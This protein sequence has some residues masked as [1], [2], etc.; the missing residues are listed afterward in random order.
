MITTRLARATRWT[1]TL[2]AASLVAVSAPANA[3][4]Y[5]GSYQGG[6]YGHGH[7]GYKAYGGYKTYGHGGYYGQYNYGHYKKYNNYRYKG[8]GDNGTA[9]GIGLGVVGLALAV[10]AVNSADRRPDPYAYPVYERVPPVRRVEYRTEVVDN[11]QNNQCLQ[12]REYQTRITVGGRSREAYGTACL[13]PDGQ[14]LQ[15]PPT[16]DPYER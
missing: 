12:T 1:A 7:G 2:V 15:G 16:I 10:A 3:E 5:H 13:Q 4:G 11:F 14:W 6:G 8:H 9:L